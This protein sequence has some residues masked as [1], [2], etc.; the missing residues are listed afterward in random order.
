MGE[1]G[2]EQAFAGDQPF[3]GAE[4][5]ADEAL[6]AAA[7]AVAE[8][9]GHADAGVLPD[10]GAGLG[11]RALAGIELDLDELQLLALDLEVDVVGDGG[12]AL[13]MPPWALAWH[14]QPPAGSD[15]D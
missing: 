11:D 4:Q 13:V 15:A 9:G 7:A 5:L 6:V 8:H 10:E 3:A 2:G 1:N 12:V 14:G